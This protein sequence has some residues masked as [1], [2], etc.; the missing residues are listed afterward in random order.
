[1][2]EKKK[3]EF[4]ELSKA[5]ISDSRN[6]IIS[7][8]DEGFTIA[9]QLVTVEG[10]RPIKIFL[11]GTLHIESLESLKLLRNTI[12]DAINKVSFS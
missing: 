5:R 7:Q 8:C 4:T 6:I 9:Q 10:T 2:N 12:D 11:K 1:M 3:M